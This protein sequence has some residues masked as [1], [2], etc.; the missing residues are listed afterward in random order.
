MTGR[1]PEQVDELDAIFGYVPPE[2]RDCRHP[3]LR[4]APM[5][6]TRGVEAAAADA[7]AVCFA[8]GGAVLTAAPG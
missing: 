1:T 4:P 8:I 3:N 6:L 5:E 2:K 7:G